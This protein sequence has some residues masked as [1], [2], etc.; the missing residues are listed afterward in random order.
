MFDDGKK[1]LQVSFIVNFDYLPEFR[2]EIKLDYVE[3]QDSLKSLKVNNF[4][5]EI[6]E[7][8]RALNN[9]EKNGFIEH[10]TTGTVTLAGGKKI[11]WKK[12]L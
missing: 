4:Q 7:M 8:E 6:E 10:Q 1:I 12:E 5:A 3:R 11:L 9:F 2:E